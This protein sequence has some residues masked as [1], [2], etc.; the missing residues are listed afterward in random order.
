M[1][2]KKFVKDHKTELAIA[3]TVV[4]AAAVGF[5]IY[6]SK[7]KT[8]SVRMLDRFS[9]PKPEW[10]GFEIDK[11]W[12]DADCNILIASTHICNLGELGNLL[13]NDSITSANPDIPVELAIVYGSDNFIF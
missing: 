3:G 7:S 12:M 10:E 5:A 4:A 13:M 8:T 2:F 9:L 6:K 1:K 11:H